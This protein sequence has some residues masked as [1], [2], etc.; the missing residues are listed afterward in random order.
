MSAGKATTQTTAT[1]RIPNYEVTLFSGN[2]IATVRVWARSADEAERKATRHVEVEYVG[3]R[4]F[5]PA[6]TRKVY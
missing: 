6:D 3:T 1:G 2:T 5:V 4:V